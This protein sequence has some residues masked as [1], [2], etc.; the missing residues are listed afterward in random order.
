MDKPDAP[1]LTVRCG[2]GVRSRQKIG[3]GS[4][5]PVRGITANDHSGGDSCER[6]LALI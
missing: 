3:G 4:L 6:E 5:Q 1:A 2:R